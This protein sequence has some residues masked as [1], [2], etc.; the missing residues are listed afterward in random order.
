MPVDNYLELLPVILLGIFFFA[1]TAYML[2]WAANK[3]YFRNMDE[4]SKVIFTEEEPEGTFSDSF[5]D[6]R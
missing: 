6:K 1:V 3:G 4:Q 2:Y 5:P